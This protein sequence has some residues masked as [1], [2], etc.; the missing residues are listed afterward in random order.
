M[1]NAITAAGGNKI[2]FYTFENGEHGIWNDAIKF[3]GS[4]T[5]YP[6]LETWLFSQ[7]K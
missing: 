2:T 1:Y 6:A 4:G 3:A 7:S 5:Q